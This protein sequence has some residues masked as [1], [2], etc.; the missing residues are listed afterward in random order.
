[1]QENLGLCSTFNATDL[2]SSNNRQRVKDQKGIFGLFCARH[3]V[4]MSFIDMFTGERY[5]Y[6]D[7]LMANLFKEYGTDRKVFLFYDVACK[8]GVN[9]KVLSK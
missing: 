5:C 9:F 3:E 6:C 7:T 4:P 1:M 8:Y 2:Q